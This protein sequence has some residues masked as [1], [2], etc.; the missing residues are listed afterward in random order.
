VATQREREAKAADWRQAQNGVGVVG[1]LGWSGLLDDDVFGLPA[2]VQ[3]GE[4]SELEQL[5]A[6]DLR[7]EVA[8]GRSGGG[9]SRLAP[10]RG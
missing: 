5:G 4:A 9:F 3:V 6:G 10:H 7:E 8:G 2:D 1:S